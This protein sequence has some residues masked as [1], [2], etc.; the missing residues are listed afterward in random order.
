M[1]KHQLIHGTSNIERYSMPVESII[2]SLKEQ[3]REASN[4]E[5]RDIVIIIEVIKIE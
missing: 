3:C 2:Y 1:V 4:P 5:S